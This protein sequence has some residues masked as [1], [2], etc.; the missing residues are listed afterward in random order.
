MG[1]I[2]APLTYTWT[3]LAGTPIGIVSGITV[4]PAASGTQYLVTVTDGCE[5]PPAMDTVTIFFYQIPPASFTSD[6]FDGCY[7]IDIYFTN[8]TSSPIG[9][10]CDW[11]FGNGLT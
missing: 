2:G 7:P 10:T 6:I 4:T 8:T 1:G 11:D 3:T 5:T 9:S